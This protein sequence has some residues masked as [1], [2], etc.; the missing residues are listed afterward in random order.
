MDGHHLINWGV[1]AYVAS[2]FTSE[3]YHRPSRQL[4]K[5]SNSSTDLTVLS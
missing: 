4:S 5:G 1:H 2:A 3:T